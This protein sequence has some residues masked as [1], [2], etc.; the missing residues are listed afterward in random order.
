MKKESKKNTAEK[1]IQIGIGLGKKDFYDTEFR[2]SLNKLDDT[3]EE[4]DTALKDMGN[5]LKKP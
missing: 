3:L 2:D 5:V 4:M 1:K